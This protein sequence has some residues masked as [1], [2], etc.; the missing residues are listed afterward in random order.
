MPKLEV[1]VME[2]KY[3]QNL[4][5]I[6]RV[7][8]NFGIRDLVLINPRCNHTGR[9]AVKY[10]KHAVDLL[11]GAKIIK[12]IKR[13]DSDFLIG[14]TGIWHKSNASYYNIYSL[15]TLSG[16]VKSSWQGRMLHCFLGG[17]TQG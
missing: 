10:S 7:C 9:E 4:G 2:P 12:G 11:R 5:Y 1:A 17:M 3:Q 13:L 14:T 8:K 16:L 6:A 15:E